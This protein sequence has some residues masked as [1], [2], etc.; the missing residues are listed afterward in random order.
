MSKITGFFRKQLP[1]SKPIEYENQ[2]PEQKEAF[3]K[4]KSLYD[5]RGIKS[6]TLSKDGDDSKTIKS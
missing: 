3:Q 4:I 1:K 6:S 5:S 2:T